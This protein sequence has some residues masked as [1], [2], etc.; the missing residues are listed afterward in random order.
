[1]KSRLVLITF[2]SLLLVHFVS[3]K[4]AESVQEFF[5]EINA[6]N[7]DLQRINRHVSIDHG[8]IL[9]SKL[10]AY[11]TQ[12]GLHWLDKNNLSWRQLP[13][14]G[15]NLNVRMGLSNTRDLANWDAFPTYAEYIQLMEAFAS[16]FPSIAR[17]VDIGVTQQGRRLLALKIT[18]NP[19]NDED[20][21]EVLY[22]ST[23]H[24]DETTGYVLLLRLADQLL[25]QYGSDPEL[26]AMVDSIE[27]WI[28]P[29]ANPD[30]TYAGGNNTVNGAQ[31]ALAN[32]WD[33]N[34][35]FPDPESGD[36]PDG[37]SWAPE[38]VAM[39]DFADAHNFVLSANFHGGAE[40]FNYPWDTWTRDHADLDWFINVGRQYADQA[41][42]DGPLGYM[43]ALNNGITNGFAW[44][45]VDGGRQD[46]MNY[47]QACREI[48]LELSNVKNPAGPSLPG[49][50]DANR[51]A[52]LD[53]LNQSLTGIRGLVTDEMGN[54]LAASIEV[55]GRDIDN[56]Q[57]ITDP[58]LGD[59][60]R[61]LLPG[62]YD[63][64]FSANG[65][66]TQ[67]IPNIIVLAGD[68]SV[69]DVALIAVA[70][71]PSAN[72][73]ANCTLLD[74]NFDSS[75]SF[76][77][78]GTIIGYI[79][80]FGDGGSDFTANPNH[81]YATS[82]NYTVSLSVTDDS[83]LSDT[84]IQAI[85]VNEGSICAA[86]AID[87]NSFGLEA[88]ANQD[89]PSQ[90]GSINV[91]DAG[92]SLQIVGNRWRR[93]LQTYS[94]TP[95]TWI[96]FDFASS[97]Q[98]EI[99]GIGFDETNNLSDAARV[100]NIWGTQ[101]WSSGIEFN[102]KYSGSGNFQSFQIPI[103][104]FYTGTNFRLTLVN[105]KDAGNKNNESIFRCIRI[106]ENT[107][108]TPPTATFTA[109]CS[110]LSCSFDASTSTDPDG[111]IVDYSWDFADSSGGSGATISHNY[112][113]PG[114]YLVSLT[115]TDN[116]GLSDTDNQI[117]TAS[118]ALSCSV[119]ID[120]DSGQSGFINSPASTCTTGT[121]IEAVPS[122][123]SSSGV[124]TQVGGDASGLG[125]ALF[126]A[127]N[128]SA[129]NADVDGGVCIV[130]SPVWTVN[131]NS[132]FSADYFHGQRDTGDDPG[133][134]F[135]LLE[136]SLD[137][138]SSF[139]PLVTIGDTRNTATWTTVNSAIPAGS[140]V[141]IRL[142]AADGA[143]PGDLIEAGIDDISIC[144]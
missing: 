101:N 55:I 135:F 129:G 20:E 46:Y 75:S 33:Q 133:G 52:L 84:M 45:E 144:N 90:G 88:Y 141:Q 18:D 81:S 38:T 107:Q 123:Q 2:F 71:P 105:D 111:N 14:P 94:L 16:D 73:T 51:Q 19:D 132:N 1:M 44:F 78:D 13:H 80:D 120:F 113:N 9:A 122:L 64:R 25:N 138:G 102:P 93:S 54:P 106:I 85:T 42:A 87:F 86:G 26:T 89:N 32:G 91:Q 61:L 121:F 68:A 103:G 139:T 136:I 62:S 69:I 108:P 56:S 118:P 12:E 125:S 126:T 97:Q 67:D 119:Q 58:A 39:M 70:S 6:K 96:E 63:L 30:G 104:Q 17:L 79:W 53:Y 10:R 29:L 43:D 128:I 114:N 4:P 37:R 72:F 65:Y 140:Q 83:G 60:H 48:T 47:W 127:S 98:G 110:D 49:F 76:D 116:D 109:N 34:R 124:V 66:A 7:E 40:V 99:H 24:G 57:V 22:S 50:W 31:R 15:I 142:Q 5:I 95:N 131:Q 8:S 41:Q 115:V 36:H 74:C 82:G 137:G 112:L 130:T 59:Y 92:A 27:I 21:P 117:I 11:T 3:A 143:G 23:M 134:D 28:N 35:N 77:S 100:F